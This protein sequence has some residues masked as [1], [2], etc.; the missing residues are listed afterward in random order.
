MCL[1]APFPGV[2]A[3]LIRPSLCSAA[4]CATQGYLRAL[5]P[6]RRAVHAGSNTKAIQAAVEQSCLR[7]AVASRAG[8]VRLCAAHLPATR[9]VALQPI[10]AQHLRLAQR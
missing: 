2:R 4:G 9:S 5:V 7:V 1:A 3:D 10:V 8:D 6:Q